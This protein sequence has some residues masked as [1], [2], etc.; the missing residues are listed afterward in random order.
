[1][2]IQRRRKSKIFTFSME[3]KEQE[4]LK[5]DAY[6]H[7]MNLS[8]YIRWLAEKERNIYKDGRG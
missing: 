1:M 7:G 5:N 6:Y 8:K 4:K 3:E 2:E